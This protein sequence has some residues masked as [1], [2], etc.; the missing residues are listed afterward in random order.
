[1]AVTKK[2]AI[3]Y[4]T[5]KAELDQVMDE[6]QREDLAVDAALKY[7]ERGLELVHQLRG[8]IARA[9]DEHA[10]AEERAH[11]VPAQVLA[12]RGDAPDGQYSRTR[13]RGC[14][15]RAGDVAKRAR[16]CVL[17]R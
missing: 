10:L 8:L 1:M 2:L 3:D 7:Y 5:L 17:R 15:E 14:L 13:I 9:R 6:L 4:S 11:V 16:Y 12:Q